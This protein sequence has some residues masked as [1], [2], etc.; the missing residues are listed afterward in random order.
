[1][2]KSPYSQMKK[3]PNGLAWVHTWMHE[4]TDDNGVIHRTAMRAQIPAYGETFLT[5]ELL[6]HG[7]SAQVET[8]GQHQ[9][10]Y[11]IFQQ[12]EL[13]HTGRIP[14]YGSVIRATDAALDAV[15]DWF[16]AHFNE[17]KIAS[18]VVT[19]DMFALPKAV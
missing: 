19:E 7:I 9:V 8:R 15:D 12:G 14:V 18:E 5:E 11:L 10:R 16:T 2:S 1:M 6:E 13:V 4:A 17:M 3:T